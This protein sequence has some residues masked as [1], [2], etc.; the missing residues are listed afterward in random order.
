MTTLVPDKRHPALDLPEDERADYLSVVASMTFADKDADQAELDRVA[1]LCATL[2]LGD[3]ATERVLAVAR[4]PDDASIEAILHRLTESDLRYALMVDAIDIA[5]ADDEIV[6]DEAAEL[7][8]LADALHIERAQLAML[9]RYVA[10]LTEHEGG[11]PDAT[12]RAA[13]GLASAGIPAAGL[14]IAT[15][16]GAP[17]LAGAG[18]AAALGVGSYAT[19]RWLLNRKKKSS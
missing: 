14:A 8:H 6:P 13:A 16:L 12:K 18:V 17:I 3:A 10:T 9:R 11:D 7:E 19:V 5:Y 4:Q 1:D 2:E 15:T